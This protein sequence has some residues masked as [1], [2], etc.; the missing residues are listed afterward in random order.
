[1]ELEEARRRLKI[2]EG[3]TFED[4][5]ILDLIWKSE[6][7]VKSKLGFQDKYADFLVKN[8]Q[9][10]HAVVFYLHHYYTNANP[11][12]ESRASNFIKLGLIEVM[13]ELHKNYSLYKLR[14]DANED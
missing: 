10:N 6:S 11:T 7:M 14:V 8:A 9:Y 1:M 12:T 2:P 4:E 13:N 3:F 5:D